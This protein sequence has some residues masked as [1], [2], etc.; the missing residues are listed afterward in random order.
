M[1]ILT[2]S[3]F[4][5]QGVQAEVTFDDGTVIRSTN[6]ARTILVADVDGDNTEDIV[7]ADLDTVDLSGKTYIYRNDGSASF[8]IDSIANI[9]GGAGFLEYDQ[10][11][12]ADWIHLLPIIFLDK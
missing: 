4:Y 9:G 12:D 11:D 6:S 7:F 2:F 5:V 3:I 1:L 10:K 8:Q